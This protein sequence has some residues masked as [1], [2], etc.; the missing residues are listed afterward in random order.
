MLMLVSCVVLNVPT[1]F[2]SHN[3]KRWNLCDVHKFRR[4]I[5]FCFSV[6]MC[7][8]LPPSIGERSGRIVQ[9]AGEIF[10]N[11]IVQTS[12]GTGEDA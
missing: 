5:I 11:R 3:K 6:K 9:K 7:S 4:F 1:F 8:K 12:A 10:Q 2:Y